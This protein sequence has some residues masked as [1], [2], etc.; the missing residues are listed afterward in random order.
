V[1][2]EDVYIS[3][4]DVLHKGAMSNLKPSFHIVSQLDQPTD[5]EL[6]DNPRSHSAKLRCIERTS[7][8]ALELP[9]NASSWL[10]DWYASLMTD[11]G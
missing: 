3:D 9:I 4:I 8:P 2:Q 6:L 11:F 7:A 1:K 5:Q 10:I